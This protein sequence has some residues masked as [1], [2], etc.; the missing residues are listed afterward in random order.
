MVG[1]PAG[2]HD[3]ATWIDIPLADSAPARGADSARARSATRGDARAV[4]LEDEIRRKVAEL[5]ERQREVL[6]LHVYQGLDYRAI[7]AAL[8][9][10]YDDVKVNLSL[11]R[12]RL[13][14]DLRERLE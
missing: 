12:K 7:A 9:C 10:S 14:E 11:A 5:P 4:E 6:V 3:D 1:S 8:E 13:R 2:R